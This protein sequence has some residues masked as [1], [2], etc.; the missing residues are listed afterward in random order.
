MKKR[1]SKLFSIG[2]IVIMFVVIYF[3]SICIKK[4]MLINDLEDQIA[5]REEE[6]KKI[7]S[8]IEDLQEKTE[9]GKSTE[10][11]ESVARDDLKMA[12]PGEY[13]YI[14]KTNEDEK[15]DKE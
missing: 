7:E 6:N 15:K 12:K 2:N 1:K 10:F 5:I 4:V 13:I 11:V 9:K 8:Q 3:F 14:E